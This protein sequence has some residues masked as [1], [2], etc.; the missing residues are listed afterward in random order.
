LAGALEFVKPADIFFDVRTFNGYDC[1][2]KRD[3]IGNY[4]GYALATRGR[5]GL[6]PGVRFRIKLECA[7]HNV[8]RQ[9]II[10]WRAREKGVARQCDNDTLSGIGMA[11]TLICLWITGKTQNDP[12]YL[13]ADPIL[14]Q[15]TGY[16]NESVSDS[17]NHHAFLAPI[18]R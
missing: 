11:M 7:A 15:I 3:R 5:D 16:G 9:R 17:R 12:T 14:P 1:V 8:H 6:K 10:G 18:P 13:P 4:R 2:Q